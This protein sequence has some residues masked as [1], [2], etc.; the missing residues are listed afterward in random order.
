MC[1]MPVLYSNFDHHLKSGQ[2]QEFSCG[3]WV[4]DLPLS[5][6]QLGLTLW[7]GFELLHA[8]GTVQ[9]KCAKPQQI[10]ALKVET[11]FVS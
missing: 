7:H 4:K 8:A 3:E 2:K 10:L 6:Q 1:K 11:K 5:L 9:K